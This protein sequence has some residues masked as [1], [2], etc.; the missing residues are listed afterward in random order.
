MYNNPFEE[1]PMDEVHSSTTAKRPGS[2]IPSPPANKRPRPANDQH[3]QEVSSSRQPHVL[4]GRENDTPLL[5]RPSTPMPG[6]M[7]PPEPP[8]LAV[9]WVGSLTPGVRH[10]VALAH[11]CESQTFNGNQR[12]RVTHYSPRFSM[13]LRYPRPLSPPAWV[14]SNPNQPRGWYPTPNEYWHRMPRQMTP[15]GAVRRPTSPPRNRNGTQWHRSSG[16]EP[17]VA[18]LPPGPAE[19]RRRRPRQRQSR[20]SVNS[21]HEIKRSP[22][23]NWSGTRSLVI[24]IH[25][26]LLNANTDFT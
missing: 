26:K 21:L 12:M 3:H 13:H 6:L 8:Q 16:S 2:A 15:T 17:R 9:R 5:D 10:P 25:F 7:Y 20:L 24:W 1:H 18:A 22:P 23:S 11:R 4:S 14:E 19:R